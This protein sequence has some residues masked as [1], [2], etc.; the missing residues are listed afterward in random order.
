[1]VIFYSYVSLPEGNFF[2]FS[3]LPEMIMIPKW[4]IFFM[5]VGQP[6]I[7]NLWNFQLIPSVDKALARHFP[8]A[9][10]AQKKSSQNSGK[11]QARSWA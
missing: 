2:S 10:Q 3:I 8:G 4:L 9:S 6:P 5:G 1:M 11:K 7:R